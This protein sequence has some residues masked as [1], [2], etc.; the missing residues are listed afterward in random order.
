MTVAR[1]TKVVC[2]CLEGSNGPTRLQEV[3]KYRAEVNCAVV[4]TNPRFPAGNPSR[5]VVRVGRAFDA[6]GRSGAHWFPPLP[7][8]P[9]SAR[10]RHGDAPGVIGKPA[11]FATVCFSAC[12]FAA[13][14]ASASLLSA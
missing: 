8:V 4:E 5:V 2:V 7:R 11:C 1:E 9:M 13:V 12:T 6:L 3:F 14:R 10:V